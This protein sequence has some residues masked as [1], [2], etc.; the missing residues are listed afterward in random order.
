MTDIR[1]AART[2]WRNRGFSAVAMLSLGLAIALNVVIYSLLVALIDPAVD[3]RQPDELR[4][5]RYFGDVHRRLPP[6]T[7]DAALETGL[8]GFAGVT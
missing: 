4:Q 1:I 3:V 8:H 7:V 6:G 2:L 5:I